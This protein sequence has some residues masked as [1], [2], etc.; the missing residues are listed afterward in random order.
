LTLVQGLSFYA[1]SYCYSNLSRNEC[2]RN[3][4]LGYFCY[5]YE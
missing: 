5:K 4:S 3:F 2:S 1:T